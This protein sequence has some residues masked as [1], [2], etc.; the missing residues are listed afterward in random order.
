MECLFE[1]LL[2]IAL[3]C[4]VVGGLGWLGERAVAE[5]CDNFWSK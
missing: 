2:A 4:V 1:L 5:E 3:T